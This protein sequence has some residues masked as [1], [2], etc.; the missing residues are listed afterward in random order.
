[1]TGYLL[2]GRAHE[3]IAKAKFRFHL[4]LNFKDHRFSKLKSAIFYWYCLLGLIQLAVAEK[5]DREVIFDAPDRFEELIMLIPEEEDGSIYEE[6]FQNCPLGA[7]WRVITLSGRPWLCAEAG[8]SVIADGRGATEPSDTWLI[9]PHFNFHETSALKLIFELRRNFSDIIF[10]SV[11]VYYSN[12]YAG[13]GNPTLATWHNLLYSPP[14]SAINYVG[15]GEIDL[16]VIQNPGFY[17]AFR[18]RSSGGGPGQ[19]AEWRLR[20]I[21]IFSEACS[22]PMGTQNLVDGQQTSFYNTRLSWRNGSGA[23]RLVIGR[24]DDPVDF[25]P[26]NGV[27]YQSA[28]DM[29]GQPNLAA[30]HFAIISTQLNRSIIE[31][32]ESNQIYHFRIFEYNCIGDRIIY[33]T[34]NTATYAVQTLNDQLSD[35][36]PT[37][38][39]PYQEHLD[40]LTY[41]TEEPLSE[42]NS[43]G[44][45]GF[46][47][48]DGGPTLST[49]G[50]PTRLDSLFFLTNG[51]NIV[52]KAGLFHEGVC[53]LE[54]EVNG[55]TSFRFRSTGIEIP[56]GTAREFEIRV[57]FMPQVTD[58]EILAL[59]ISRN[60]SS[61]TPFVSSDS[62]RP[63]SP[64]NG[65]VNR[66]KVYAD[67]FGGLVYPSFTGK[68]EQF[69]VAAEVIDALGN[70]DRSAVFSLTVIEG[71]G[72]L[73]SEQGLILTAFSHGSV[74]WDA[75]HYH[76]QDAPRIRLHS[77]IQDLYIDFILGQLETIQKFTFAGMNGNEALALSDMDSEGLE[78]GIIQRSEGLNAVLGGGA[79]NA[80]N[81]PLN[82]QTREEYYEIEISALEGFSFALKALKFDERRSGTGPSE[83]YVKTSSDNFQTIHGSIQNTTDSAQLAR[84]REVLFDLPDNQL[85]EKLTLRIYAENANQAIG[86]WRISQLR[87]YGEIYDFRPPFFAEG[88]PAFI[89]PINNGL[90]LTLQSDRPAN[91]HYAVVNHGDNAPIIAQIASALQGEYHNFILTGTMALSGSLQSE[92]IL[93]DGLETSSCYDVYLYLEDDQNRVGE[94]TSLIN[95][96][97]SDL[98][99]F[100]AINSDFEVPDGIP[101]IATEVHQGIEVASFAIFD[102]G[103]QDDSP[104]LVKRI[105]IDAGL[106]PERAVY[107]RLAGIR[108]HWDNDYEKVFENLIVEN[109]KI[110]LE[111]DS[112]AI[113]VPNG[114]HKIFTLSLWLTDNPIVSEETISIQISQMESF[115]YGTQFRTEGN[116]PL[117]LDPL[118]ISVEA[119][120]L[121]FTYLP[122]EISPFQSFELGIS[123]TDRLGNVDQQRDGMVQVQLHS[124]DGNL[125]IQGETQQQLTQGVLLLQHV[126][127][128][129][130]GFIEISATTEGLEPAF[131]GV[132]QVGE[133]EDFI[134][135]NHMIHHDALHIPGNLII[136]NSGQL[137]LRDGASIELRGNLLCEGSISATEGTQFIFNGTQVQSLEGGGII[138]LYDWQIQNTQ[139]IY[140]YADIQFK[141]TLSFNEN[142]ILTANAS[143]LGHITFLSGEWGSAQ[144]AAMP[145]GAAILGDVTVQRYI[146]GSRN[147]WRFLTSPVRNQNISHWSETIRSFG[148]E[149]PFRNM[150]PTVFH[151]VEGKGTNGNNG[152]D[153]W[154]AVRNPEHPISNSAFNIFFFGTDLLNGRNTLRNTG[155]LHY[156]D[157]RFDLDF[158]PESFGG[159]GWNQI[160]NPYQATLHWNTQGIL[161]NNV[162]DAV[163]IWDSQ[164]QRYASF[165]NGMSVNGTE[166]LIAPGQS[167]FVKAS[168]PEGFI[169]FTEEAKSF[170]K[171][172]FFRDMQPEYA[173]SKISLWSGKR[174]LDETLFYHGTKYPDTDG[175]DATKE[176][177]KLSGVGAEIALKGISNRWQSILLMDADKKVSVYPI[178]IASK[179]ENNL[180]LTYDHYH[181]RS[182]SM[183]YYILDHSF[184]SLLQLQSGTEIPYVG[185][186][187]ISDEEIQSGKFSLI[188]AMP[189]R[190]IVQGNLMADLNGN[191]RIPLVLQANLDMSSMRICLS[192]ENDDLEF[193]QFEPKEYDGLIAHQVSKSDEIEVSLHAKGH[194]TGAY[195]LDTLGFMSFASKKPEA[196]IQ[197]SGTKSFVSPYPGTKI[198]IEAAEMLV[199]N[200]QIVTSLQME[201]SDY[202]EDIEEVSRFMIY[203]NPFSDGFTISLMSDHE[204]IAYFQIFDIRGKSLYLNRC[205]LKPGINNLSFE[206]VHTGMTKGMYIAEIQSGGKIQRVKIIRQ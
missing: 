149:G 21:Q 150:S 197:I 8:G 185:T 81:W 79:F 132:M 126:Y 165:V 144:L 99:A 38:N 52:R 142:S 61:Q 181:G 100:F 157:I 87:M 148:I 58:L 151:Y 16:S 10:P 118:P 205:D 69:R 158:T 88:A 30:E 36:I 77:G 22:Q 20:N 64:A 172:T 193:V 45:F 86:T 93:L 168:G 60:Q 201:K 196:K 9:S 138:Q 108:I 178:G 62:G 80:S 161:K 137:D 41:Q 177:E 85:F 117:A 141:G 175:F 42:Q 5:T 206:S 24:K 124:G 7:A 155:V 135:T 33:N 67:R 74:R 46:T 55:E 37:P 27:E 111:L 119:T 194:Y 75:L 54:A 49:D 97:T 96:C 3:L 94:L 112:G 189:L 179:S 146:P 188:S 190:T 128:D 31:G 127:Y 104:T 131:S 48:R 195:S 32:L 153:G 26:Q 123:A 145:S 169:E 116:Q 114:Q 136:L 199:T 89:G 167:F 17:I 84:D 11:E 154:E 71:D 14:A 174:H 51:S 107:E 160:P 130:A 192:W 44:I 13:V 92:N 90:L 6:S 53:L 57:S 2:S 147:G 15:S 63:S 156:G 159:G 43:T 40:Y 143:G 198:Y 78:N 106:Q 115:T 180:K 101:S 56:D 50:L 39:Y 83:W 162:N 122:E 59:T 76:G 140:N 202:L 19:A 25:L 109:G 134:V 139:G 103:T 113:M 70:R 35:I 191:I 1:M 68:D 173:F 95:L 204:D 125:Q 186:T 166:P 98:D 12:D 133:P 73:L 102:V 23:G 29:G 129:R 184:R 82:T 163:Y 152:S 187:D 182:D 120:Q 200:N 203:P 66:V 183:K 110:L 34:Q 47:V 91:V 28:G 176:A 4:H 72:V 105:W 121:L 18:Y 65:T 170:Q 164:N 171:G